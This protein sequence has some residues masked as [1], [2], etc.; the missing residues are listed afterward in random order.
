V[1][2]SPLSIRP[3]HLLSRAPAKTT[4]VV[5]PS[6]ASTSYALLISTNI[7]AVGWTTSIYFMIVAPSLDIKTAPLLS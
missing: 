7:L 6:P 2:C 4:T 1:G 5:V 3:V